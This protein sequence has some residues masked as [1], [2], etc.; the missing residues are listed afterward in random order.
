MSEAE[1]AYLLF[2]F[3]LRT[4]ACRDLTPRSEVCVALQRVAFTPA[5]IQ[6]DCLVGDEL[7]SVEDVADWPDPGGS[8]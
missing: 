2:P 1:K 5:E 6:I 4:R 8:R 3:T 7:A